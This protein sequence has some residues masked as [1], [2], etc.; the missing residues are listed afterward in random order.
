MRIC[1]ICESIGVFT[2]H[3]VGQLCVFVCVGMEDISS[4]FVLPESAD[5]WRW[6]V[7]GTSPAYSTHPDCLHF[8]LSLTVKHS[9]S[10]P[11][12]RRGQQGGQRRYVGTS[13]CKNKHH[14]VRNVRISKSH[15][16][17]ILWYQVHGMIVI[18]MSCLWQRRKLN[19]EKS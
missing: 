18:I 3:K 1:K 15:G 19:N 17:I 8:H 14:G 2:F 4:G 12:P 7:V 9:T 11:L 5:G 16:M 13:V 6:F 10:V